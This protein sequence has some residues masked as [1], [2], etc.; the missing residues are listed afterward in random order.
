MMTRQ[1]ISA[2][3]RTFFARG[4][5]HEPATDPYG[6]DAELLR[7]RRELYAANQRAGEPGGWRIGDLDSGRGLALAVIA[8]VL[9]VTLLL[10][11]T[12]AI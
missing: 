8:V 11:V 1:N 2:T 12:L 3:E 10:G 6:L 5:H 9:V 4:A 7:R